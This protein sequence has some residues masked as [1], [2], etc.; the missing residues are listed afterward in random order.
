MCCKYLCVCVLCVCVCVCIRV[1]VS[2][3]VSVCVWVM[4]YAFCRLFKHGAVEDSLHMCVSYMTFYVRIIH[5]ILYLLVS[6]E[7]GATDVDV[8]N[9][10]ATRKQHARDISY[11]LVSVESAA[12][13][14]C[15]CTR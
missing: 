8:S 6:V 12:T 9:A 13:Y 10:L 15:T 5:D 11:L 3:S 14:G 4:P 1:S 2:V 7:S